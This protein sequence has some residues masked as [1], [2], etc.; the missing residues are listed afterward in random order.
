MSHK[1]SVFVF[2][3]LSLIL[4]AI[5][6]E[7]CAKKEVKKDENVEESDLQIDNPRYGKVDIGFSGEMKIIHFDYDKYSLSNESRETLKNNAEWIKKRGSV[8][9]QVEGHCDSRG[10][11]GYNIALGQKRADA[12][13]KYLID[14][15]V[16]PK[17]LTTI[18][19][20]EER[21]LIKSETERAW[22]K[23]RRAEFVITNK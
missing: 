10:T 1:K 7:G 18:S 5:L 15:G 20:G 19:Y 8:N 12:V 17:K 13:R 22:K 3:V 6:F 23:N 14:L 21:P 11:E 16:V 2:F 9:V 4:N